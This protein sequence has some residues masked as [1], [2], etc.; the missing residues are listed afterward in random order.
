MGKIMSKKKIVFVL[1]SLFLVFLLNTF[2]QQPSSTP[3]SDPCESAEAKSFDWQTGIWQSEDGKQV[4][5]IKKLLGSCVIMEIWKTDGKETAVAL[6]SFDDGRQNKTG[7]KA[8]VYSWVAKAFHQRWEGRK[9]NGQW[10]FYRSWFFNG[11]AILSRTYWTQVSDNELVRYVEQSRDEGKTWKPWV[12]NV[13]IRKSNSQ[14]ESTQNFLSVRN[15]HGLAFDEN[16]NKTILFGGADASKVLNDTWEFD[17]KKWASI[18]TTASPSPRTFPAMTYDS[19]RKK[20]LLFG[21]NRVLFGK[22]DND[23]EFLSDFWEFDGKI[24]TKID[25]P[26]PDGRAEASFAFDRQ[27]QKAVLFGGYRIENGTIKPFSDTWEWNGKNWKKIAEGV[28][29]AR[30]GAAIAYDLAGKK[31]VLFG[32]GIKRGGANETWEF[33][34]TYWKEIESAKSEPR[35]NSTMVYDKSLGKIFRFGGWDGT[36]RVSE[37]WEF[38]GKIWQKLNTESPEA[39]NHTQMVYDAKRNKLILFGGHNGDFV[40]GDTWEFDGNKWQKIIAVE[41][42]KRVENGH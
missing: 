29:T 26:T 27:R 9:E 20:I 28:P 16:S 25:V 33:D 22:D 8:W 17:G 23:Y 39:R 7:E 42:Q 12:K 15:A 38:D 11:E 37:T 6:K 34:G 36:K 31:I 41:P 4:H 13:F 30:S 19:A 40:L 2:S 35:Y 21:G 1:W 18:E 3:L 14:S 5:E 10:R 32:G 24:W